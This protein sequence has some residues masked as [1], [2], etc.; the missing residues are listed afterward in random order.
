MVDV[1][2]AEHFGALQNTTQH[3]RALCQISCYS[4]S[5]VQ[6]VNYPTPSA[7]C[8]LVLLKRLANYIRSFSTAIPSNYISINVNHSTFFFIFQIIMLQEFQTNHVRNSLFPTKTQAA[9][10]VTVFYFSPMNQNVLR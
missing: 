10:C 1:R 3:Y 9:Y 8:Y 5:V 6:Q 4:E 7:I 2:A